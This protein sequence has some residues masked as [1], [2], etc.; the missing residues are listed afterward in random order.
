MLASSAAIPHGQGQQARVVVESQLIVLELGPFEKF[1]TP[2]WLIPRTAVQAHEI[3]EAGKAYLLGFRAL[4]QM[5]MRSRTEVLH[6]C[7]QS[8]W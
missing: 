7:S 5:T 4:N 2:K 8:E 1:A 6:S 3:E